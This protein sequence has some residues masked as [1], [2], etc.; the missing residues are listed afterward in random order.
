M[1]WWQP[2]PLPCQ[3][4]L[5]LMTTCPTTIPNRTRTYPVLKESLLLGIAIAMPQATSNVTS[6][7]STRPIWYNMRGYS[8]TGIDLLKADQVEKMWTTQSCTAFCPPELPKQLPIDAQLTRSDK[9][10]QETEIVLCSGPRHLTFDGLTLR[11]PTYTPCVGCGGDPSSL[12]GRAT[13]YSQRFHLR[14][15]RIPVGLSCEVVS[16]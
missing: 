5:H 9:S 16:I 6:S 7:Q 8:Q 12:F 14:I 3:H 1:L 13:S 10:G 15:D 2:L 11:G 4:P